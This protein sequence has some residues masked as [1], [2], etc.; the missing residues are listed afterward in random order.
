MALGEFELIERFFTAIGARRAD[1]EVGIGDDCAVLIPPAGRRLA[2]TLDT[3]VEGI[4]FKPGADPQGLGHKALAVNLS[5]LAAA[6]AEP[7]WVTLSLTLPTA[8]ADWLKAFAHGFGALASRHGVALVGGD[9]TRGPLSISVQAQGFVDPGQALRR[10]GARPG[11][12]VYVSGTLGDAGLALLVQQGLYAAPEYLAHLRRRLDRPEPR[13]LLGLALRGLAT[14]AIDVSD[15]LTSDLGHVLAASG[16]G[17]TLHLEQLPLSPALQAYVEDSG[18]WSPAL[19]AGD[20]YELCFTVPESRQ[21]D[22]EALAQRLDCRLS[23]I[24]MIEKTRG[25]R[26]IDAGGRP[27][28]VDAGFDHFAGQD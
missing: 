26:C 9:T 11:D 23:W 17:A 16:C 25:L 21:G 4:H 28:A 18:D 5:D 15:G 3:L 2:V 6:G 7:A 19:S 1:V 10:N 24:G 20:D 8:D 13:V 27:L 22:V 14:S 12:L